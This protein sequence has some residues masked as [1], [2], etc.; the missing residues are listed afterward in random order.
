MRIL[1]I[2]II[3]IVFIIVG[4]LIYTY[5]IFPDLG[6]TVSI[7]EITSTNNSEKIYIKKKNWGYTG[8]SQVIVVSESSEKQFEPNENTEY[9]FKGLSPF[10]YSF[11]NDT[12]NL[13]VLSKSKVPNMET[14]FRIIQSE[15]SGRDLIDLLQTFKEKGLKK[16][17]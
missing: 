4:F 13:F 10:F 6:P 5:I 11:N 7:V 12:L 16:I 17:P 3:T 1:V 8:D 14:N 2:A 15:L 9:V